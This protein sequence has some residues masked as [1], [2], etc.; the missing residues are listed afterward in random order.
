[1]SNN[2]QNIGFKAGIGVQN[3]A[4]LLCSYRAPQNRR[5]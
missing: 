4:R 1:M 2:N 3:I 5:G